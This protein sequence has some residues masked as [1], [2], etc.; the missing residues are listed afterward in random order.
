M[1]A[2][3]A[4]GPQQ[5]S[6]PLPQD[7]RTSRSCLRCHRRKIRCD[8]ARPCGACSRLGAVCTYPPAHRQAP[9]RARSTIKDITTR[10]TSLE[11]S[12]IAANSGTVNEVPSQ[13]P[14]T[15]STRRAS[16]SVPPVQTQEEENHAEVPSTDLLPVEELVVKDGLSSHY[17]NEVLLSRVVR[18][19]PDIQ[20]ALAT[21]RSVDSDATGDMPKSLPFSPRTL[22]P[23]R[24]TS[25]VAPEHFYP[26]PYQ[27]MHL[28]KV[29]VTSVDPLLKVLHIPTTQIA[30]YTALHQN[31]EAAADFHCLLFAIFFAATT[32][33][34][35]DDVQH[36]LSYDKTTALGNFREGFERALEKGNVFEV[37][38]VNALQALGIFLKSHRAIND[39]RS[40][41][42]FS[43]SVLR[44]AYTIG[45]HRDG[46]DFNFSL[47]DCEMRRRLFWFLQSLDDRVGEDHGFLYR[48]SHPG[49]N[50]SLPLNINDAALDPNM[51]SMPF[52]ESGWTEMTLTLSMCEINK[53]KSRLF[54]MLSGPKSRATD[55]EREAIMR[56]AIAHVEHLRQVCNPFVPIQ[57]AT[58]LVSQLIAS[59]LHF[60]SRQ[61]WL[62]TTTESRQADC[63]E[64]MLSKALEV[65]ELSH[66]MLTDNLLGD[67]AW[68]TETYPQH[69][70]LLY[71][72]WHLSLH[73]TGPNV[74]RAWAT[75]EG[76]FE[77][78]KSRLRRQ[79]Q[80]T[81]GSKWKV[82]ALME[83]RARQARKMIDGTEPQGSLSDMTECGIT[84]A[85]PSP[86][87]S[88]DEIEAFTSRLLSDNVNFDIAEWDFTLNN[89]DWLGNLE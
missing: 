89:W 44:A 26:P 78:E 53:A 79:V 64:E 33:L 48:G 57:R 66:K 12:L 46:K 31:F 14:G 81:S 20:S 30:V 41:W 27:A 69:H 75:I 70:M 3:V 28:W 50:T 67:F 22:L 43:G 47:F 18:K 42:V 40:A 19:D 13:A 87:P 80:N 65:L 11:S 29:F 25:R 83:K 62:V 68:F 15:T 45:L 36:L 49:S 5:T 85:G 86:R 21:P 82:L 35:T 10:L 1:D 39:G 38:T 73:P 17:I 88:D 61:Q 63:S 37:P 34:S 7:H 6:T 23:T 51:E 58:L 54:R 60:V 55:E 16:T 56:T 59:K 76:G 74:D 32:A 2:D 4:N 8:K 84:D 24:S 77:L 72:L 9:R 71:V 52:G